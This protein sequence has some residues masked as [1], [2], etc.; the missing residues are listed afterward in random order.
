M[1]Q[2]E[3]RNVK[4]KL[5]AIVL[6][7]LLLTV[8]YACANTKSMPLIHPE[9]AKGLGIPLTNC[10]E[11]HKNEWGAMNNHRVPDFVTKH[12]FLA[13]TA[14][15]ACQSCHQE[16]FCTDCHTHK[17]EIK[18]SSKFSDSPERNLAHRGDYMSQ[19]KIDGRVNPASCAR[20]HGRQNNE[21][22]KSCHR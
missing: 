16:S 11:C 3:G 8:L 4:S 17:E 18:P 1:L 20:C 21:G 14:R 22:C 10:S 6:I 19:H 13:S 7:P 9:D 12:R 5:F 2:R 15:K